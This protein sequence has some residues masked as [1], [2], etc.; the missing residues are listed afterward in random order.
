MAGAGR[1]AQ[2]LR[3]AH[4]PRLMVLGLCSRFSMGMV[5]LAIVLFVRQQSGSF[6]VAGLVAAAF[7]VGNGLT[8]PLQGRCT[9]RLGAARVLPPCAMGHAVAVVALVLAGRSDPPSLL[10]AALGA[11]A[12]ACYPPSGP[13][14]RRLLNDL[15]EDQRDL[16]PAL[17]ALD[18]I[19]MEVVFV[20]GPLVTAVLVL[21]ASP[22]AALL[23]ASVLCVTSVA[24]LV[25]IPAVRMS[26]PGAGGRRDLLGALRS[27]GLRTIIALSVPLGI[28]Y[29]A[30]E[31]AVIAFAD[32]HG[33]A[34]TGAWLLAVVSTGG[35][36]GGLLY[37]AQGHRVRARPALMLAAIAVALSVV[38]LLL[39]PTIAVM[40]LLLVLT[41]IPV[42]A[43]LTISNQ[44]LGDVAVP[45]TL[46]EAF[47]WPMFATMA[48][49]AVGVAAGGAAIEAGSWRTGMVVT[50]VGAAGC[51]VAAIVGRRTIPD[52]EVHH[53]VDA[54]PLLA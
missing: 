43:M 53:D 54:D 36:A 52:A 13:V 31:V 5:P 33:S 28:Y 11:A 45:G 22:A 24:F 12:G 42:P 41:G 10:L 15:S 38:P 49:S 47:T 29:G 30:L 26:N 2:V 50:L 32:A 44:V 37:G 48:G 20:G 25:R 51:A 39:A 40:A 21:V 1:F 6:A 46:T 34:S 18:S 23:V 3:L 8:T 16:R 4:V 27:S 17:F 9:D 19:A 7:T 14:I 35:I